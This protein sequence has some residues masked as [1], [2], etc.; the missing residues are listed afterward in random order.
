MKVLA[1]KSWIGCW[2]LYSI[3]LLLLNKFSAF[4]IFGVPTMTPSFADLRLITS[5]S[6][7]YSAGSWSMTSSSCDPWG[8]PF[9]YPSLWVKIFS[10][11]DLGEAR[12]Y[13]LGN[14]EL[15]ILSSSLIYWVRWAYLR[16]NSDK[17]KRY[18]AIISIFI[19]VSPPILLLGERGNIDIVIFAG[20]TLAYFMAS[21]S[22]YLS[23]GLLVSFLGT[24]KL[25]PFFSLANILGIK[26]RVLGNVAIIFCTIMGIFLIFDELSLI[27]SRSE[28]GWNS[29]SYGMSELPLLLLKDTFGSHTKI[30]AALF[31]VIILIVFALVF[32]ILKTKKGFVAVEP[33]VSNYMRHDNF[34]IMSLLF[35]ASF[36]TGTSYDY[37]L[38]T[39]VPVLFMLLATARSKSAIGLIT[40]VALF[41]LYFGHLTTHFGK[42]GLVL[43][44]FG[45][46]TIT[47]F[48][49]YLLSF[50]FD[51]LRE[52]AAL[53]KHSNV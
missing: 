45:D 3:F 19:L 47:L 31:G 9:N 11:L 13:A 15:V 39:S 27:A 8:R 48:A 7:C 6:D 22:A 12:T 44:I 20:M 33:E 4:K 43:N 23:S 28:N 52:T 53:R 37:R 34:A 26:N 24:L 50:Y 21:R 1:N 14:L 51:R 17:P 42:I 25:Y 40:F 18:F 5:A 30:V 38:I 49:S 32:S 10:F 2:A 36:L 35:L 16:M 29:I 41:S 46:V